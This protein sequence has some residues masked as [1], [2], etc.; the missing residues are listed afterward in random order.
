MGPTEFRMDQF[1]NASVAED[2]LG[3]KDPVGDS[4]SDFVLVSP[5]T[6]FPNSNLEDGDPAT[7][8]IPIDTDVSS[9][10]ITIMRANDASNWEFVELNTRV[11][12]GMAYAD[13][14]QGGLFVAK[15]D[16]NVGLIAGVVVAAFVLLVVGIAVG[17][18]VIYF[19]V[20]REKWQKTKENARKMKIKM[21][22]SFAKQV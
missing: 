16:V 15:S 19:L 5:T 9:E 10:D 17:G 3:V 20:R 2:M 21:T 22:R 12:D 14:R 18:L 6:Q 1:P 11:E 7:I 8:A 13:T 4:L